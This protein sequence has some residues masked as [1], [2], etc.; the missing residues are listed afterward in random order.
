MEEYRLKVLL[1]LCK[2]FFIE[3][4]GDGK[5]TDRQTPAFAKLGAERVPG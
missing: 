4:A 2:I 5:L 1:L 3:R